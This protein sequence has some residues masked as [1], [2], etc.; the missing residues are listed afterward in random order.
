MTT[1]LNRMHTK[2]TRP[3]FRCRRSNTDRSRDPISDRRHVTQIAADEEEAAMVAK[4][5]FAIA[6]LGITPLFAFLIIY[7]FFPDL[8]LFLDPPTK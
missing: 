2:T 4:Y 5:A 6:L 1:I 3:R 8:L 7:Y